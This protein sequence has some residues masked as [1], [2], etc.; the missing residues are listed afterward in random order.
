VKVILVEEVDNLG[1]VGEE[2]DVAR[3]YARNYLLPQG[4][5]L[6]ATPHNIRSLEKKKRV[7]AEQTAKELEAARL[8]AERLDGLVLEF[9]MKAGE[10]GKLYG[11]VTNMDLSSALGDKGFDIERKR[12]VLREPIKRLGRHE[13]PLRLH[14]DLTVPIT[15]DVIGDGEPQVERPVAAPEPASEE[16]GTKIETGPDQG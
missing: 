11:S 14:R 3:G 2:V 10:T 15:V 9:V 13:V 12:I 1:T 8:V 7:F 4:L 5:A 6:E 16:A